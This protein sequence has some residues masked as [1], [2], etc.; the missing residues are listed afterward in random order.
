MKEEKVIYK[1]LSY[2]LVGVLYEVFNKLGYG[3]KEKFYERAIEKCLIKM[4]IKY[5]KQVPYKVLFKN[6]EIGRY[7]FDFLIDEK[8]ILELKK[9]NY[10]SKSNIEQVKGYL[11]AA[12]LKLAIL[13]NYTPKGVKTLRVL[14]PNNQDK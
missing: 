3:Y 2:K 12:N 13:A 11:K 5:K 14:N 6:E 4:K 7:F 1:E 9:G 10:F 8:I